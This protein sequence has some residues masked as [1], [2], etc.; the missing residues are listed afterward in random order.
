MDALKSLEMDLISPQEIPSFKAGDNITVHYR[1]VEGE[2]SRVQLFK[3]DVLQKKGSG[4]TQTFTV[5]KISNGIGVERIFP[6][7]SP[8]IEKIEVNKVGKVRR[9]RIFYLRGLKG[10]SARIKEK[11]SA[12]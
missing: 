2:K 5:R 1:I 6:M 3:G 7:F 10:K 12:Q 8:N 11:R 9:S 4:R